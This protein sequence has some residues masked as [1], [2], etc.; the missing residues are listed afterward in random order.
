MGII[1]SKFITYWIRS[2][3]L[4]TESQEFNK[5]SQD[6]VKN[7]KDIFGSR[8]TDADLRSFLKTVPTLSLTD[9]GKIAVINNLMQLAEGDLIKQ[10]AM[11]EIVEANGGFRPRNLETL[12][13]KKTKPLL[14]K[15]ASDFKDVLKKRVPT[16]KPFKSEDIAA[17]IRGEQEPIINP[18]PTKMQK[19]LDWWTPG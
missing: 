10:K 17:I 4:T 11:E 3:K 5:L 13:R 2:F 18:E 15:L 8:L 1:S 19:F 7:A 12:V 9:N 16:D 14:D 6:F